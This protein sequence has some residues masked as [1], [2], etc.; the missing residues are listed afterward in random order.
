MSVLAQRSER[1]ERWVAPFAER[2]A[3]WRVVLGVLLAGAVWLAVLVGASLA[4]RAAGLGIGREALLLFLIS[5]AAL[6]AGFGLVM[7]LLHRMAGARLLGPEGRIE[8]GRLL[9]GF[10]IVAAVVGATLLPV[11]LTGAAVRQHDL[12]TWAL[13]LPVAMPALFLQATAEEIAFRGY[14]QGMLAARY[15]NRLV[16]W[17]LPALLFG[18]L[19][20]NQAEVEGG[21]A[22]LL[23]AA[24]TLMGLVFGDVTARTGSLSAAIGLH[25]ANNA[26][27]VLV[28]ATPSVLSGYALYLSPLEPDDPIAV[29]AALVGNMALIGVGYGVFLLVMTWRARR[30][31]GS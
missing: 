15:R 14:L 29:R 12:I 2:A 17:V 26:F 9:R 22:W 18:A 23:V 1:Y 25:F 27:A 6:I 19:H 7:R 31:R 8:G 13:W 3:P 11:L 16:W 5:F 21:N 28:M 20:W 10:T 4:A 30:A 24:A